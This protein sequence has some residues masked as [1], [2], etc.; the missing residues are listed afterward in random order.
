VLPFGQQDATE[1][2]ESCILPLRGR[3]VMLDA[4]L[5]AVYGSR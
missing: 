2:I 3:K 5:A 4:D 1:R